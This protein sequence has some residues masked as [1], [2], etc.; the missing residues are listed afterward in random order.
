MNFSYVLTLRRKFS[1]NGNVCSE[2]IC[3]TYLVQGRIALGVDVAV[4]INKFLTRYKMQIAFK[5]HNNRKREANLSKVFCITELY[6][7]LKL[8]V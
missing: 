5:S 2:R 1:Y 6:Q 3:P 8:F 7:Q 4:T